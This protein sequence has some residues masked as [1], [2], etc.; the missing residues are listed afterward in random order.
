MRRGAHEIQGFLFCEPK[1]RAQLFA[2]PNSPARGARTSSKGAGIRARRASKT[3]FPSPA[4]EI[5]VIGRNRRRRY[6]HRA[7]AART[8]EFN[9]SKKVCRSL[10]RQ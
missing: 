7:C 4:S 10:I 8:L 3:N 2:L 9:R 1:P 6:A 5:I